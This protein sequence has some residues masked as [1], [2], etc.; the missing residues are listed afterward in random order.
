MLLSKIMKILEID[1]DFDFS[2]F[3]EIDFYTRANLPRI[4]ETIAQESPNF[5]FSIFR[6]NPTLL[7]GTDILPQ[8][9]SVFSESKF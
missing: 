5:D 3:G 6:K 8:E 1:K 7:T 9:A 2:I 4:F